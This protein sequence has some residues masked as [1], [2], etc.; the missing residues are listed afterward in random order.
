MFQLGIKVRVTCIFTVVVELNN[1]RNGY[2]AFRGRFTGTGCLNPKVWG[3][4]IF[5]NPFK[6]MNC[7]QGTI[8][9]FVDLK[10]QLLAMFN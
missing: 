4:N 3:F 9:H 10:P 5:D 7:M 8:A 1:V 6:V 2:G